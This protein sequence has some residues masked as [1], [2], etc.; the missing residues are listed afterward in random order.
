MAVLPIITAPDPR[1]KL[2]SKPVARVDAE[3][4]RLMDDMLETMY[5]A[6][7]IGLAAP[8]VGVT[9]RVL[10]LDVAREGETPAP[11]CL[12]NPEILWTSDERGSF[13]EGCLSLPD[14]YAPVERPVRCRVRF[15]DRDDELREIEAEGLLATCI[16]HEIDHLEGTL[17]VDHL[18]ALKRGIILRKLQKAKK[19]KETVPA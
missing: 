7:G 14:Q 9:K 3:I 16:Q 11:L 2:R 6:P 12:A 17:F 10:V 19:L 18:S 5:A 4:R 8:Q 13:E 1:L 15:L